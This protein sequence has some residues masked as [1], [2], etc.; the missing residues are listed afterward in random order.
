MAWP[1]FIDGMGTTSF[2]SYFF[3]IDGGD[4]LRRGRK[5]GRSRAALLAGGRKALTE[6]WYCTVTQ[7]LP[8]LDKGQSCRL[9]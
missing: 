7:T 9:G 5:H 8:D 3:A 1:M 6:L 4:A 2:L